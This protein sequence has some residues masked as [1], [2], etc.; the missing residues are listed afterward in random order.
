[1]ETWS[2]EFSVAETINIYILRIQPYNFHLLGNYF[3]YQQLRVG[4]DL[5]FVLVTRLLC[6]FNYL[7]Y[8]S[9]ITIAHLK[10]ILIKCYT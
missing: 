10:V 7:T 6:L 4:M 8:I 9:Y 3:F 2:F 1:M 5:L